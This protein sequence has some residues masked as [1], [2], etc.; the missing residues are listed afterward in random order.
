MLRVLCLGNPLHSNDAVGEWVFDALQSVDFGPYVEV[1]NGGIGG[2]TLLPYFKDCECVLIVD[3]IKSDQPVGTRQLL[4][5]LP[6]HLKQLP[7]T[8]ATHG[9]DLTTLLSMLPLYVP[10]PPRIDLLSMSAE[11]VCYFSENSS[12]EIRQGIAALC[13]DVKHYISRYHVSGTPA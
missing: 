4:T 3:L 11:H 7:T 9:G 10:N 13:D 1:I 12:Q 8:V 5:D 2:L 6:S